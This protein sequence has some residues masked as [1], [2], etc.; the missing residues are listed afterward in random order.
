MNR[1]THKKS[2]VIAKCQE[3]AVKMIIAYIQI[4]V[5]FPALMMAP[6]TLSASAPGQPEWGKWWKNSE[7]V[8]DLQ[9]SEVQ[10][11]QIEQTFL[12]HRSAL[13]SLYEELQ[14][15]EFELK[16]LMKADPIDESKILSQI[17]L[18]AVSRTAL[19]KA[20]SAMMLDI[21][22]DLTREQW[23]KLQEIRELRMSGLESTKLPPISWQ[24]EPQSGE[25]FYRIGDEGIVAPKCVYRP[26]PPYTQQAKEAKIEGIV[27][28]QG[29][30]RKNGH[31][32]SLKVLKPL[33]YG[34][35]ESAVNI[36]SKEW[37]FEPGTFNGQPVD[38][39]ANIEISF[40]LY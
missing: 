32:D 39:Q 34:L 7:I 36:V 8:N 10:V 5:L 35:D 9:L 24:G 17:E 23:E 27:L 6:S 29:V 1:D 25:K 16:M 15:R 13:S 30:I 21:R 18:V 19:E 22:K 31:I 37:R 40:R 11:N 20:N 28:L 33:G 4:L 14:Q 2:A 12:H 26:F 38:V 3:V